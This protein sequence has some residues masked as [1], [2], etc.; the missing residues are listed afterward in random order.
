MISSLPVWR[1]VIGMVAIAAV[2]GAICH[3]QY[4]R[5]STRRYF[6]RRLAD[7]DPV[8][9]SAAARDWSVFGL[10]RSSADLL[11]LLRRESDADVLASVAD[12]VRLRAW[13]PTTRRSTWELREWCA[14]YR[15]RH[16]APYV[17]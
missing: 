14:A 3:R 9:R 2:L 15:S 12:A 6:R 13:E 4:R 16:D 10:H 7:P 1:G 8:T 5:R 17:D 11:D